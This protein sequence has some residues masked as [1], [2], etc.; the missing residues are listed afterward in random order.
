MSRCITSTWNSICSNQNGYLTSFM[1]YAYMEFPGIYGLAMVGGAIWSTTNCFAV[2]IMSHVGMAMFMLFASSISCLT[3]WAISRFGLFGVPSAVPMSILLNYNGI[4][5]LIVGSSIYPFIKVNVVGSVASDTVLPMEKLH[6]HTQNTEDNVTI[7]YWKKV[8]AWIGTVIV[9]LS[10]GVMTTPVTLLM[11]RHDIYPKSSEITSPVSFHFSF[12]TGV[13]IVSVII[14]IA[15]CFVRKGKPSIPPKIVIPS[16]L[17]GVFFSGA[18]ACFFIANEQLSPTISYPICMMAPGW[19][20]SAWSVFYFREI[21]GRR[22]L[23]LLGT[24]YG[25]TLF[26]VLV[27]TASRVVQL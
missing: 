12:F 21:S 14:F 24:A 15:Y 17:S 2:Q 8:I 9:G 13:M 7:S 1:I 20:T 3:G 4:I 18:M 19:I 25:F 5:L 16:M 10:L 27:I 6:Q 22:N 26:G 11:T 23:L